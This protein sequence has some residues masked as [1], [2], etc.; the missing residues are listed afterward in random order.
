MKAPLPRLKSKRSSSSE[1]PQAERAGRSAPTAVSG[2]SRAPK[3]CVTTRRKVCGPTEA[4]AGI[5]LSF[6]RV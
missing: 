4:C 5:W 3:A 2:E 6:A 1:K